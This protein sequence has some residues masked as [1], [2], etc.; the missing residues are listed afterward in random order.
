MKYSPPKFG[1]VDSL[2]KYIIRYT[3]MRT[4][5]LIYA[6]AIY[7]KRKGAYAGST[8]FMN[9]S[10]VDKCLEIGSTW[11]GKTFQRTGLNRNC[12]FLLM[13]YVFETLKFERL[14]LRTDERNIQSQTA[15][16]AIGGQYEGTHRSH[17]LMSDGFRRNTVCFSI[18]KNEWEGIRKTIFKK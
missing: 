4:Q 10:Q 11:I 8:S 16:K 18:L 1:T 7:D 15:I 5:H 13:E 3:K 17:L 12:K 9:I 2:K 6:F 14:E